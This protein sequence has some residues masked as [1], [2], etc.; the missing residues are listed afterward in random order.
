[1]PVKLTT[2]DFIEKSKLIH[3]DKYDYSLVDYIGSKLKVKIICSKH[4]E[5]SQ[6]PNHHLG[7]VGCPKCGGTNKLNTSEIINQFKKVH[8]DKYDYSLVNYKNDS[9]KVDIICYKHGKFSQSPTHHKQGKGCPICKESKG[10]AMVSKILN[11]NKIKYVREKRFKNCKNILTLPF[12]FYL[13]ENNVCVE[14]HGK[15][16]FKMECHFGRENGFEQTKKR[17][18]IKEDFC[19]NNKISLIIIFKTKPNSKKFT[20]VDLYEN[21]NINIIEAL[22]KNNIKQYNIHQYNEFRGLKK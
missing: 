3:G 11:K 16:H 17:D 15:Q 9:C 10:E 2:E 19:N 14:F 8:E 22:S 21:S 12:D 13:P 1:M 5:F 18:K 4:G 7:N 20:F 6:K